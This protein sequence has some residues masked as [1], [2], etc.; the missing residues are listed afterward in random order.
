M[1]F[2]GSQGLRLKAWDS[3][4]RVRGVLL[5]SSWSSYVEMAP[6]WG[7]GGGGGGGISCD[8]TSLVLNKPVAYPSQRLHMQ[9]SIQLYSFSCFLADILKKSHL[10]LNFWTER[11]LKGRSKSLFQLFRSNLGALKLRFRVWGY[12]TSTWRCS[13]RSTQPLGLHSSSKRWCEWLSGVVLGAGT[14][15]KGTA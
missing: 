8:D 1:G 7:V 11:C 13:S 14:L 10:S 6:R 12:C 4:R 3:G 15:E 2:R 5:R 9:A